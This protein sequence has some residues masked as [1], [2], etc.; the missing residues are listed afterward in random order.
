MI[1]RASN[2]L[3]RA[4]SVFSTEGEP[5][6]TQ[7]RYFLSLDRVRKFVFGDTVTD[8]AFIQ[9]LFLL[10][11][12]GTYF[13]ILHL[14]SSLEFLASIGV[15]LTVLIFVALC[16]HYYFYTVGDA[17]RCEVLVVVESAMVGLG[18]PCYFY[19]TALA[20]YKLPRWD[21]A[22][23][24][25][26]ELMLG[27][28]FPHGQISLFFDR[29]AALGPDSVF[30]RVVTE[31]L[32]LVYFSYYFWPYLAWAPLVLKCLLGFHPSRRFNGTP[33]ERL[34]NWQQLKAFSVTWALTFMLT[35]VINSFFPAGSP[36]LYFE[37]EYRHEL[38]GFLLAATIRGVAKENRSANSFPSGH[39]AETF[40]TAL[41]A[42]SFLGYRRFGGLLFAVSVLMIL[43]TLFLRYHYF[44]DVVAGLAVAFVSMCI[45]KSVYKS[46][47]WESECDAVPESDADAVPRSASSGSPAGGGDGGDSGG[48]PGWRT[49]RGGG[50]TEA[51]VPNGASH[52]GGESRGVP[53]Q[54]QP[55]SAS[56]EHGAASTEI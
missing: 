4:A 45:G 17:T 40:G 31:V 35:F 18:V 25:F 16:A 43:A 29:S 28:A 33:P 5:N 22:L 1:E 37:T 24:S 7:L 56:S 42:L 34:R 15:V 46:G 8:F 2:V 36:R 27:W 53:Y 10:V 11:A 3:R 44:S 9:T 52:G 51:L 19:A 12:F 54:R 6:P 13:G 32:Q 23:V 20:I 38:R 30:S 55:A 26:D 41:A 39:V 50:V 47:A 49:S 14:S 21:A 48:E